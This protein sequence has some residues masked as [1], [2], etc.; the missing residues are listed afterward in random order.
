MNINRRPVVGLGL[1]PDYSAIQEKIYNIC[2]FLH[3][4]KEL[5]WFNYF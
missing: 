3:I 4:S 1:L 5:I 2:I